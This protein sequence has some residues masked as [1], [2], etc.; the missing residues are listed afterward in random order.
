MSHA[1]GINANYLESLYSVV[2]SKRLIANIKMFIVTK[3][4]SL[5][6]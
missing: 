4:K 5:P 6:R 2:C 3:R 1:K